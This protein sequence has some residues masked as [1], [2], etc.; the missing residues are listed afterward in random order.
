LEYANGA[1]GVFVT[2]TADAPGT[3]RFEITFEMGKM[4]CEGNKLT[5]YKLDINERE[6]CRTAAGGFDKPPMQVVEIETD[7]SYPQHQGVLEAF[8]ANILRGEP[9]VA[10]GE[11]G[12]DGLLLSNA[13]HLSSWLGKTVEIP[14][15][16][17]LFLDE[18]N[19][20]RA[21]SRGKKNVTETTFDT[22][23][24]H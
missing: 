3:D 20:R 21:Q 12:L 14:F 6:F 23:G 1:T 5:L 9:M 19:M 24:S 15:D 10:K 11:E 13:M 8:A 7:G 17:A 22:D 18:L 4:V 2:T 16:E